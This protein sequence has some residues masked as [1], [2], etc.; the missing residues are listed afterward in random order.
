[1]PDTS[2]ADGSANPD[3]SSRADSNPG[4][5]RPRMR[6]NRYDEDDGYYQGPYAPEVYGRRRYA[7]NA[8]HPGP[9]NPQD[10]PRRAYLAPNHYE[11]PPMSPYGHPMPYANYGGNPYGQSAGNQN[12]AG[13]PGQNQG[14]SK[15]DGINSDKVSINLGGSEG[16]GG[17]MGAAAL[18]AA[19]GSRNQSHDGLG[20]LMLAN[21]DND[22]F[23]GGGIGALLLLAAL[24]GGGLG[25]GGRGRDCDDGHGGAFVLSKLGS[26]EGAVPLAAA[27]IQN[28][29]C[30]ATGEITSTINQTGLAQLAATAGVKD[31]VQNGTAVLLQ[32]GSQNTQSILTA[33]CALSSKL[34]HNQIA[35]LQ[36]QLGVAQ[37]SQL[38]ERVRHHSDGVEVRVSQ[39][40]V[41][42]QAQAQ[43]QAQQQRFDDDRY[44]RLCATLLSIGNQ[45][46]YARQGQDVI[47][48][49]GTMTGSGTQTAANTQVR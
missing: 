42:G 30:N 37:L 11:Y 44:N 13:N 39:N 31:S 20:A 7:T 40:V 22:G 26:I 28:T 29:I 49:G 2:T 3:R 8:E 16:G 6:T 35:D 23:G 46:M 12:S 27:Q 18:V 47:N 1:M 14:A 48:F 34:D 10:Y 36:R 4:D 21:R 41:Q 25:F 15:M 17:G 33:I 9:Y 38:E 45:T 5:G 24:G 32:A 43:L 19:L